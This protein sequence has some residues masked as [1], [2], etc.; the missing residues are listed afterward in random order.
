MR[1]GFIFGLLTAL[2]V[3]VPVMLA[4]HMAI[5][6]GGL[7]FLSGIL[8]GISVRKFFKGESK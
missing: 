1:E 3:S 2:A 5:I 6:P 7:V 4:D 8:F